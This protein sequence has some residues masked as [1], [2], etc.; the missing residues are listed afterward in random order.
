[1]SNNYQEIFPEQRKKSSKF[2]E[3]QMQVA[4][5][6]ERWNITGRDDVFT[7][8]VYLADARRG[9][10]LLAH[11]EANFAWLRAQNTFLT[12]GRKF[13]EIAEETS[14]LVA[15]TMTTFYQANRIETR[16]NLVKA[17]KNL[18]EMLIAI[19]RQMNSEVVI[20]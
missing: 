6:P 20:G 19:D 9:E 14:A 5:E 12:A 1:M 8:V 11:K 18:D 16:C 17:R 13:S 2:F 7:A 3:R 4:D 10:L 15:R